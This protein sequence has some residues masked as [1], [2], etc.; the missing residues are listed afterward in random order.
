MTILEQFR[1]KNKFTY[2]QLRDYIDE[3]GLTVHL[4]SVYRWCMGSESI[5]ANQCGPRPKYA[6]KLAEII[7]CSFEDIYRDFP[8]EKNGKGEEALEVTGQGG[9]WP[10]T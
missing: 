5:Y 6:K 1:I 3:H 10:V 8:N 7:G 2:Q 4:Q 9:A